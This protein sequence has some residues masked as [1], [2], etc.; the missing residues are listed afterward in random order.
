MGRFQQMPLSD[1]GRGGHRKSGP[2]SLVPGIVDRVH[3]FE[4]ERSDGRYLGDV[5]PDFAQRKCG[6][7]PGSTMTAPGGYAC[8]RSS[9]NTLPKAHVEDAGNHRIDAI[10]RVLVRHQLDARGDLDPDDVWPWF[11]WIADDDCQSRRWRKPWKG[12][13]IDLLGQYGPLLDWVWLVD[14]HVGRP[15]T[16][17]G[18]W[19]NGETAH[20]SG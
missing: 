7:P 5:G 10:L 16:T 14:H 13:P 17:E 4:A 2:C 19:P 18:D 11:R 15:P 9:S 12:L 6:V 3:V 8:N 20:L 1:V